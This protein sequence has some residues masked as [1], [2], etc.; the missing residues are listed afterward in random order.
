MKTEKRA[1]AVVTRA[2]IPPMEHLFYLLG[3]DGLDICRTL[4]AAGF[5]PGDQVEIRPR[6]RD[7]N[8][9]V[10][11]YNPLDELPT[12]C[13]CA[14]SERPSEIRPRVAPSERRFREALIGAFRQGKKPGDHA[15]KQCHPFS[16][17][18]IEGFQCWWHLGEALAAAPEGQE[19][20]RGVCRG[21]DL[22][23]ERCDDCSGWH[24]PDEPAEEEFAE[25]GPEVPS[26]LP[27]QVICDYGKLVGVGHQ[28]GPHIQNE[29][30]I[31]PRPAYPLAARTERL[32]RSPLSNDEIAAAK[33]RGWMAPLE[34]VRL[35]AEVENYRRSLA[36]ATKETCPYGDTLADC[37]EFHLGIHPAKPGK[38]CK[39]PGALNGK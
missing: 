9:H 30:C 33:A 15:C 4:A 32:D 20:P 19:A 27:P 31:N 1:Y 14:S 35:L 29:M 39:G 37:A 12:N 6:F 22:L 28:G 23:H 34:I 24:L 16:E 38:D 2:T 10:C 21:F 25:A 8:G 13:G 11:E 18:L 17:I 7:G 36:G 5:Q 3:V 26:A